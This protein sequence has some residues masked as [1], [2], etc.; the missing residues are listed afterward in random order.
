LARSAFIGS[1]EATAFFYDSRPGFFKRS[2]PGLVEP[3]VEFDAVPNTRIAIVGG[4]PAGLATALFAARQGLSA[5]V[6]EKR[7]LPLDKACGEGLMP[8]GVA[9]LKEMGVL[10]PASASRPF[11]GIRYLDGETVAEGRFRQGMGLGVRRTTLVARMAERASEGGVDL[12]YGV[13]VRGFRASRR[14]VRVETD[15]GCLEA[16]VLVGADGLRSRIRREAGLERKPR[17]RPRY[18]VRRHFHIAP[19]TDFV[20]VHWGPGVEAYVTPVGP[21]EVGVAFLWSGEPASFDSFLARFPSLEAR[22]RGA[23]VASPVQGAGPFRQRVRRRVSGPRVALVGDAA[24]FL[25]PLTGEGLSLAFRCARALIEVLVSGAPLSEYERRYRELSKSYYFL[26]GLLL[27]VGSRPRLRRRLVAALG[28]RP[29]VFQSLLEVNAG[30]ASLG[31]LGWQAW[32]GLLADL[33]FPRLLE[34]GKFG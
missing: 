6:L 32:A 15:S 1:R 3:V 23:P 22:L 27:F 26:T 29:A 13:A 25:D 33:A 34:P 16:D 30:Q 14:S 28:R 18:G 12:R 7:R 21:Q 20:E 4:G 9:G 17:G 2:G 11:V 8:P 5:V 31:S 24:G 19:W 10:I